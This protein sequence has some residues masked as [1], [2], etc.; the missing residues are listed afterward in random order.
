M[1]VEAPATL[2]E[3][4]AG[5]WDDLLTSLG[6]ADIYLRR[7]YLHTAALIEPGRPTLL[8]YGSGYGDVVFACIVRELPG[9]ADGCDLITPYGYGG[10]VGAGDS[11]PYEAFADA[12]A[13]WA[14]ASGAV[15]AFMRF[16]PLFGNHRHAPPSTEVVE[17]AGTVAWRLGDERDL[18]AQMHGKHRNVVRK[19]IA[20]GVQVAARE[21]PTSLAG[22]AALYA[23][24]MQRLGAADMYIFERPYWQALEQTLAQQIVCFDA[25]LDD[26]VIAS[27]LCF[28]TAPWLHY[29]L[30]AT[31]ERARDLGASNLVLYEA[32]RWAQQ[33]GYTH[34]HLGGGVGGKDDSLLA[35]KRRFDPQGL[36]PSAIGKLVFDEARYAELSPPD[37]GGF[38][39]AYRMPP[40][41]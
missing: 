32:A 39:P 41:A 26:E 1:T 19:A 33:H 36:V 24:T 17:L 4:P 2:R 14:R 22:F 38:F 12:L 37:S 27:A 6:V 5:E 23:Q 30:G 25:M 15:T 9:G 7:D 28:A 13:D 11:P 18:L 31:A 21:A 40:G 20:A 35:F 10:P 8:H 34:L 3:V 16:H 29:H